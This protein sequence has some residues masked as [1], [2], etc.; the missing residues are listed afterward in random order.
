MA[1]ALSANEIAYL[2]KNAGWSETKQVRGVSEVVMA[3]AIS[4]AES[5]GDPEAVNPSSNAT[6]LW[7][8]NIDPWHA[9]DFGFKDDSVFKQAGPNAIAAYQIFKQQGWTAWEA[10]SNGT[11]ARH[12][13]KAVRGAANPKA[14]GGIG[15]PIQGETETT[16][17]NPVDAV[18][19]FIKGNTLRAATFFGGG[20]LVI[21]ALVLYFKESGGLAKVANMIPA[22]KIVKKV[23][24]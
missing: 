24:K 12:L 8:I 22:G 5:D 4:F 7:Q 17:I 13:G 2:A 20:I 11:Y 18:I 15:R 19:D 16:I 3:T 14:Y 6:G 21:M 23:M 1:K 10:Y 9:S